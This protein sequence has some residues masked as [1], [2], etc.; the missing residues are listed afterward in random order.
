MSH[1]VDRI[2]SLDGQLPA[3]MGTEFIDGRHAAQLEE[4]ANVPPSA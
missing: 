2:A 1:G 3:L 4:Y